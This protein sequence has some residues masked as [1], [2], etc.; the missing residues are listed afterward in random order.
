[1]AR[2]APPDAFGNTAREYELGRPEW[3]D[4]L[5]DRVVGELELDPDATVLDLA[6]GTGKLTRSLVPR[7]ARVIAV[8]PD[9]AM[10]GVLEEVV[11]G[12]EALAGS[13]EAIPLEANSVD[14]V[15]TAEAFHWFASPQTVVEITRVLR[16]GGGLAIF[17]NVDFGEPEPAM[18]DAVEAALDE[19]FALGGAPGLPKVLSGAWREPL[20]ASAFGPLQEAEVER[21]IR[22]NREGW[23]ANML[24]VSSIAAQSEAERAALA[25][26]LRDLVP[27]AEYRWRV[28]TIAYWT[29]LD[30]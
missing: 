29:R 9:D 22:R 11:P 25:T 1:M 2:E 14:A 21:E 16:P 7:F 8:E 5:I 27:E 10:R 4:E 19:A 28:R 3:P 17:W 15:F 20:E 12:A 26:R 13:A 18:G 24:S 23:L 30:G 6:A